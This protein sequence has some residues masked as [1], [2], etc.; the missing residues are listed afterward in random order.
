MHPR[1]LDSHSSAERIEDSSLSNEQPKNIAKTTFRGHAF[2]L[3]F[4]C[5]SRFWFAVT[6]H[7]LDLLCLSHDKKHH[8][9]AIRTT[10][11]I[12]TAVYDQV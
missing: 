6:F 11:S 8:E 5:R 2:F 1:S 9:N 7:I 3:L 12:T 10:A 4:D